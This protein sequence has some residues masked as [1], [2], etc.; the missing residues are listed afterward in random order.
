MALLSDAHINQW[1]NADWLKRTDA[2]K[3]TVILEGALFAHADKSRVY[4]MSD[5]S[6]PSVRFELQRS[7]ILDVVDSAHPILIQTKSYKGVRMVLKLD[8]IV[9]RVSLHLA[10]GLVEYPD[11]AISTVSGETMRIKNTVVAAV[12]MR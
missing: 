10:S 11:H 6:G 9:T 7:D 4:F 3:G 5:A 12:T 1:D 8:A 2:S